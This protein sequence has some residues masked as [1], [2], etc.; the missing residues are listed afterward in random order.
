MTRLEEK[1]VLEP[2]PVFFRN[3]S[4]QNISLFIKQMESIG[5]NELEKDWIRQ[6]KES[7]MVY[8][9]EYT[10]PLW[11]QSQSD[12]RNFGKYHCQ[13]NGIPYKTILTED[14]YFCDIHRAVLLKDDLM[15]TIAWGFFEV[16][17]YL[18]L[19]TDPHFQ[20]FNTIPFMAKKYFP[21]KIVR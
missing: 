16:K 11:S 6:H 8:V 2:E 9:F 21:S 5:F 4:V 3:P 17:D 13:N 14:R 20:K 19:I 18:G 12:I 10:G 1:V 15:E 7:V